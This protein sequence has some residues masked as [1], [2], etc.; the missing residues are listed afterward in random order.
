MKE[1]LDKEGLKPHLM[2][3][4]AGVH[5]PD[6][7]HRGFIA[8]PEFPFGKSSAYPD[9]IPIALK[10]FGNSRVIYEN[11]RN[12]TRGQG[13]FLST[14]SSWGALCFL[15]NV[16][17]TS[18]YCFPINT[19]EEKK[20]IV[21]QSNWVF[22]GDFLTTNH[23]KYWRMRKQYVKLISLRAGNS[24]CLLC[25]WINCQLVLMWHNYI[26][27]NFPFCTCYSYGTSHDNSLG[28][29]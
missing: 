6:V 12:K 13:C 26:C 24:E 11:N 17:F 21:L 27:I 7:D 29:A 28:C 18:S 16:C 2:I 23:P 1:A 15:W 10:I 20:D 25:N 9:L 8:L 14:C 3:Q 22:I 4:P 5:T 19:F